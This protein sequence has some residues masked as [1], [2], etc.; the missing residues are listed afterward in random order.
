MKAKSSSVPTLVLLVSTLL[1]AVA[2]LFAGVLATMQLGIALHGQYD[3]YAAGS[4]VG[5]GVILGCAALGAAVPMTVR[6]LWR[7]ARAAS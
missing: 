6:A 2:G 7:K 5:Y 4:P 1:T 3:Y